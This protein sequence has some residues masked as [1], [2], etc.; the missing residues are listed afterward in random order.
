VRFNPPPNWPTFPESWTPPP[1]WQ[2]DEGLPPVPPGWQL[3]LPDEVPG[4]ASVGPDAGASSVLGSTGA[5][6]P[7]TY[8]RPDVAA[9]GSLFPGLGTTPAAPG[10]PSGQPAPAG[11]PAPGATDA[12]VP[13][14]FV[15]PAYADAPSP[16]LAARRGAAQTFWIGLGVVLLGAGSLVVALARRSGGV[17][18]TGGIVFGAIIIFRAITGYVRARRAGAPGYGARGWLAV[19]GGF[20]GTGALVGV[21][22]LV[23]G[24]L[25]GGMSASQLGTCWQ[26]SYMLEQVS[27]SD[28]HDYRVVQVVDDLDDCPASVEDYLEDGDSY[29]CLSPES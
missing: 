14:G 2:P 28:D 10:A 23:A 1:G 7:T 26:G 12:S 6:V 22:F 18:W 5:D 17:V 24:G 3:W 16:A 13:D 15:A 9:P 19:V 25:P 8:G 4:A 27:C 20:V 11:Y 21:A 29:L